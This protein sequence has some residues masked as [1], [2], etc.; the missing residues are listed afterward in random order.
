MHNCHFLFTELISVEALQ[1]ECRDMPVPCDSCK[2]LRGDF[3]RQASVC[4][5]GIPSVM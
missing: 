1:A 5:M 4:F 2:D 3:C